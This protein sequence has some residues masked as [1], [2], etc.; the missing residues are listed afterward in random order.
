MRARLPV[1]E[2]LAT[3][4]RIFRSGFDIERLHDRLHRAGWLSVIALGIVVAI[5]SALSATPTRKPQCRAYDRQLGIVID[6]D[7]RARLC[8]HRT[9][10]ATKGA[11]HPTPENRAGDWTGSRELVTRATIEPRP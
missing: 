5:A 8:L 7:G 4:R 3:R 9:I 1:L 11:E 10:V 2:P 6:Q